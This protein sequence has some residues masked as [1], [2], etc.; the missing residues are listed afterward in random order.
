MENNHIPYRLKHKPTGLYYKPL[1]GGNSNLSNRG[2]IYFNDYTYNQLMKEHNIWQGFGEIFIFVTKSNHK[3]GTDYL[4]EIGKKIHEGEYPELKIKSDQSDNY[5]I[6]L[7]IEN[8]PEHWEKE[9][10]NI[11]PITVD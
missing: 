1:D 7:Y 9:Y 11:E 6:W 4:F 10:L 2:K 3:K 8:N 5:C